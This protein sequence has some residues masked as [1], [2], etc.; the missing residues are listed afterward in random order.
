M[1]SEIKRITQKEFV[2]SIPVLMTIFRNTQAVYRNGITSLMN[3]KIVILNGLKTVK[4]HLT[5][6]GSK[7]FKLA[8]LPVPK[9]PIRIND[10]KIKHFLKVSQFKFFFDFNFCSI[11]IHN[12]RREQ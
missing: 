11:N 6:I 3:I 4:K 5:H 1:I 9:K 12:I 7:E 2:R 8:I 10:I